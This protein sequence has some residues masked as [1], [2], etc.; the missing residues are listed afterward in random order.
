MVPMEHDHASIIKALGGPTAVARSLGDDI[1]TAVVWNWTRRGIPWRWRPAV[2]DLAKGRDIA[3]P[4]D[5]LTAATA[6]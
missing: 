4:P 5:F 1:S 2:A 6:A 3:T